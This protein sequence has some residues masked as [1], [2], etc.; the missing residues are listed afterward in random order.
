MF[1][2]SS[3]PGRAAYIKDALAS[4]TKS[5]E[6]AVAPY[7]DSIQSIRV[8]STD[9]AMDPYGVQVFTSIILKEH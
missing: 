1:G 9:P 8:D 6:S 7:M 3:V 5:V 2:R 4:W